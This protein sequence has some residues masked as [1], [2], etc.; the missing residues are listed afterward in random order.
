MRRKMRYSSHS[1]STLH[2][3]VNMENYLNYVAEDTEANA[4]RILEEMMTKNK[5]NLDF[6]DI[7]QLVDMSGDISISS[8]GEVTA[9]DSSRNAT[10]E[11]FP[12][13]DVP[14]ENNNHKKPWTKE[15]RDTTGKYLTNLLYRRTTFSKKFKTLKQSAE[16]LANQTGAS[17]SSFLIQTILKHKHF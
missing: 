3:V 17:K 14:T 13:S 4:N 6:P 8:S 11:N 9:K 16:L 2:C 10:E 5:E 15:K 7:R 1:S 12:P